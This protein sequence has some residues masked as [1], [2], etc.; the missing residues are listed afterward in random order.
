MKKVQVNT[1]LDQDNAE[2]LEEHADE[3]DL[4]KA[5]VSRRAI[6]EYLAEHGQEVPATDGGVTTTDEIQRTVR[7]SNVVLAV[8]ILWLG[9]VVAFDPPGLFTI[10]TGSA[11]AGVLGLVLA[12]G[13]I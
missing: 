10:L 9:A 7:V 8:A 11:L 6:R 5:E 13:L 12:R 1:R 3:H 4:S 2:R